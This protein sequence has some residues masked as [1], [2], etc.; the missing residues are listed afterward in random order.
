MKDNFKNLLPK[1]ILKRVVL[2]FKSFKI[3]PKAP[4]F[5]FKRLIIIP[6]LAGLLLGYYPTP[7]F[8]PIKKSIVHAQDEPASRGEQKQEI[9]ASSFPEPINLPH[10]GYLSARFSAFH[11]GVDIASG[12]GMPI[13]PIYSGV[14]EDTIY[15]VFAY[16]HHVIIDHQNGY[17][18]LYAHM[19]RVYIKKGD[20]VTP[21]SIIGEVGLTGHTSG[22]HTHL[23]I[24]K[25]ESY[26]DP[27]TILP[28][29]PNMPAN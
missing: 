10:P 17:K 26:I 24:T 20:K 13:H 5:R 28:Q 25:N 12:L 27:L 14:V 9:I 21:A 6:L 8:P 29:I 2:T 7:T 3:R 11:P 22:P 16:G 23:E 4:V 1:K 15:D 18:S 19:G